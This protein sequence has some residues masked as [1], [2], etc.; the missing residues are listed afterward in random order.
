MKKL[1]YSFLPFLIFA[2]SN[3]S[4]TNDIIEDLQSNS[5]LI[6]TI[7]RLNAPDW[8]NGDYFIYDDGKLSA[9]YF[10]ECSLTTQ[11]YHLNGNGMIESINHGQGPGPMDPDFD[12]E[13]FNQNKTDETYE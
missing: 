1:F 2:C 3:S 9:S 8:D 12:Q 6:S 5:Y 4:E 10:Q 7:Q 11:F 13:L